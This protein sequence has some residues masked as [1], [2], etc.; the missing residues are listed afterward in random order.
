MASAGPPPHVHHQEE[1]QFYVLEG[2]PLKDRFASP[3]PVT[4]ETIARLLTA[5]AAGWK[6]HHDSCPPQ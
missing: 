6:E 5:E 2:E 1:E 3:P 4:E